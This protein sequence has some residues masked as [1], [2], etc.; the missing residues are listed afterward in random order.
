MLMRNLDSFSGGGAYGSYLTRRS[1]PGGCAEAAGSGD[2]GAVSGGQKIAWRFVVIRDRRTL[3]RIGRRIAE[4][5]QMLATG[6]GRALRSAATSRSPTTS[7]SATCCRIARRRSR[8]LLLCAH[9][10]GLG[11]CWLGCASMGTKDQS[12]ER[13]SLVAGLGPSRGLA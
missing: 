5:G 9:I 2:G 13:N 6:G 7:N 3:A 4:N 10:L 11:A 8:I 1:G 12:P